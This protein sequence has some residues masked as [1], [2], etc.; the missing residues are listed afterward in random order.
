MEPISDDNDLKWPSIDLLMVKF[1]NWILSKKMK[2]DLMAD[3][4]FNKPVFASVKYDG[5]NVGINTDGVM[6]GRNKKIAAGT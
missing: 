1:K 5:T 6:Y 2:P 4:I 3:L